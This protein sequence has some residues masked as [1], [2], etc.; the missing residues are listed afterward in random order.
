MAKT[1]KDKK[2]PP[3]EEVKKEEPKE[4]EAQAPEEVPEL[5]AAPEVNPFEEK[6]NAV[7]CR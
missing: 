3:A 5:E 1:E 2:N 4:A 7:Y 6:Y